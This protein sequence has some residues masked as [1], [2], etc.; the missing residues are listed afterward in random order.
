M[1]IKLF[2]EEK[3]KSCPSPDQLEKNKQE[4]ISRFLSKTLNLIL[5]DFAFKT[6][7]RLKDSKCFIQGLI[8]DLNF[9]QTSQ[10][11]SSTIKEKI[12]GQ[13]K[14]GQFIWMNQFI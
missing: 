14:F 8:S 6:R 10:F 4:S 5:F 13:I 1:F 12:P 3:I 2:T 11:S 9:N 7:Y